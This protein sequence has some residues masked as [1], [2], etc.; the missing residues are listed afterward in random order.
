MAITFSLP[1]KD[2]LL[3]DVNPDALTNA[4]VIDALRFVYSPR[5]I[6]SFFAPVRVNG[7]KPD[8]YVASTNIV[9]TPSVK[10]VRDRNKVE[11]T[12]IVDCPKPLRKQTKR[13]SSIAGFSEAKLYHAAVDVA[14]ELCSSIRPIRGSLTFDDTI[15]T[16]GEF[17]DA[18]KFFTN[19]VDGSVGVGYSVPGEGRGLISYAFT[20]SPN[21]VTNN[22]MNPV[23]LG[24]FHIISPDSIQWNQLYVTQ[25]PS[26]DQMLGIR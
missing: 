11:I 15:V 25:L 7:S 18:V 19:S 22:I 3:A 20:C 8:F 23:F 5:F 24:G 6:L 13:M 12:W 9:G 21:E 2:F 1:P 10:Y 14:P 26:D 17:V 4:K 16:L